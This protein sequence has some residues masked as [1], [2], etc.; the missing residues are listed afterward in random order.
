MSVDRQ[1]TSPAVIENAVRRMTPE[2]REQ[3]QAVRRLLSKVTAADARARY[4]VGVVVLEIKRSEDRYGTR[5]VHLLSLAL[6]RNE[7]TLYRYSAVAEAWTASELEELLLRKLPG[8]EPISWCHLQEIA[9]APREQRE[10]LLKQVF[11]KGLSL[12]ELTAVA[13]GSSPTAVP[14]ERPL[15]RPFARLKQLETTCGAIERFVLDDTLLKRLLAGKPEV[16]GQTVGRL[17]AAQAK[18][19]QQLERNMATLRKAAASLP[20]PSEPAT[21]EARTS[22][23]AA[24]A[25]FFPRLLAGGSA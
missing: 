15:G 7:V 22:A 18:A 16:V 12:R 13:R 20:S 2:L 11:V 21:K 5:A 3:Y 8:G 19:V 17:L 24:R 23:S 25:S 4:E 10:K 14:A 9:A 1:T 6:G